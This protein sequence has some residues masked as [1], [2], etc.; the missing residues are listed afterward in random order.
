MN[1]SNLTA[2]FCQH[3]NNTVTLP[4]FSCPNS[5]PCPFDSE[6]ELASPSSFSVSL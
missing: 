5:I 6:P 4:G 2:E 1:R 3:R